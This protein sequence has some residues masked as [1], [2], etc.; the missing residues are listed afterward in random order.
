LT[1]FENQVK[2]I[3]IDPPYNTGNTNFKYKDKM[4]HKTWLHF[5]KIRLQIANK[6]LNED[7]I[8]SVQCDDN[9]QAYLKVLMD[10][11]FGRNN[12]INNIV[13]QM[14]NLSGV[15]IE[16]A[17][18]GRKF[19]KIKEYILLYAKNKNNYKLNIPKKNKEKWDNEYNIIIIDLSLEKYDLIKQYIKQNKENELRNL[20]HLLKPTSLK[21]YLT[22]KNIVN[23]DKWKF[24]NSYR[25]FA[26]K[27]N[28]AIR[29]KAININFKHPI[30]CI[31]NQ[32]GDLKI[33]K[34]DFNRKTDTARI[35][36]VSAKKTK[37]FLLGIFGMTLIK[38]T[39]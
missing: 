18:Q 11:I 25:I 2:L 32:R 31:Y 23:E 39:E 8:I 6:F 28:K 38:Q 24:E 34:T 13:V 10:E 29:K 14:S 12:F 3:Y 15:K 35:E 36:L 5:M 9:E 19:P 26:S 4:K 33:I 17:I 7:G 30:D 20:L 37:K 22:D 27:P 21:K 1:H 16:H